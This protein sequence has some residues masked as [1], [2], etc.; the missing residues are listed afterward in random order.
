MRKLPC[1]LPRIFFFVFFATPMLPALCAHAAQVTLRWNPN[2]ESDIAGYK[3]YYGTS[4]SEYQESA[5]VGYQTN[6][7]VSNLTDGDVYFFTATAYDV[8]GNESNYSEELAHLIVPVDSDGDGIS[9]NNETGIYGT[10]PYSVDTDQDGMNDEDE[11]ELWQDDWNADYDS[12]GLVNLLDSD[13]DG[14]GFP[15][16]SEVCHGFD[17][18]DDTSKPDFPIMEIGEISVDHNWKQAALNS[19]FVNPVVVA[20]PISFNDGDPAVI[21]IRNVDAT[22]FEMRI[23]EWDYLD[24]LHAE[25]SVSYVVME[26]GNY[27][28]SD[29]SLVEAGKFLT[30]RTG[31]SSFISVYFDQAFNEVPVVVA[32]ISTFNGPDTVTGRIR[33]IGTSSFEFCMQE[34]ETHSQAHTSEEISVIAWEVSSGTVDGVTFEIDKTED[35]VTD[36][37]HTVTFT[38][39]FT[40]LPVFIADMQTCDGPDPANVRWDNKDLYGVDISIAEEQSGDIETDHTTEVVGYMVFSTDTDGDGLSDSD[41]VNLYGTDPYE[42]DTDGDGIDDGAEVN[43]WETDGDPVNS[44]DAD[45]DSDTVMNLLD[46]DSDGD[47]FPDGEEFSKG[48]DPSDPGSVP[49]VAT[50][51]DYRAL[52]TMRSQD[53]DAV[54][55]MFRYQ[56][57]DNYYRFSWDRERDYRRLVKRENGIF[58]L[59]AEDSVPYV[60]GETYE[61]EVVAEGATLEVLIDGS[62]IFSVTDETFSCGTIALY[63]WANQGAVF[64]DVSVEDL[65][66]GSVVLWEDFDDGGC[67]GWSVVDEGTI[68]GPSAW[69]AETGALVQSSNIY[70]WP[71]DRDS[72]AKLGTYVLLE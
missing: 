55:V 39:S 54:G 6:C 59:L 25:E 32:G 51:T 29:G 15:D 70:S 47:G 35:A 3:V 65:S 64:D 48:A 1:V 53:N 40:N 66:T 19:A 26:A 7:T 28:L 41:E 56:D 43:Y 18:S 16:G 22:G 68:Q 33:N 21:S 63:S 57:A 8:A 67:T 23:Q 42:M 71:T 52:L 45:Y 60:S 20:K 12:D 44:W 5:D 13:S 34:Q 10:D 14:D 50:W 69:S 36:A 37:F 62:L 2:T 31:T 27:T 61:V 4:S 38:Q 49:P 72:L 11:V 9:D 46:V 58:T 24:S 17:P 30:R